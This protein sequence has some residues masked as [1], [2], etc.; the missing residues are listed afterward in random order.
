MHIESLFSE[1]MKTMRPSEI[2]E[3]L[4][5]TQNPEIISF[6]G[7]L[8]NPEAFP[9][10]E[11]VEITREILEK[12]GKMALQYGPTEGI[13]GFREVLASR[14]AKDGM[15]A[16][17]ENVIITTGSQQ[18]LDMIGRVFLDPGDTIIVELPTYLGAI[19]A[20]RAYEVNFEG[21]PLDEEGMKTDL[22]EEKIEELKKKGITPKFIYVVP[23][24][25]NPAGVVMSESRRRKLIDIANEHDLI[26]IEDDPYGKLIY[27][28]K[29][30]KPIKALDDEGR[31]I[32]LST[33]SKI[34]APGFRL[35][36]I[37][38][39]EELIR[40]L[41]IAKQALDLCSNTFVQFV[42]KEFIEG[43]YLDL[44]IMKII[45]MYRP[46]RDKMIEAIKNYFP[47]DTIFYKPRGGMFAWVTIP[48]NI[49][50]EEMFLDAI[51][52]KVAYIHGKAFYVDGGGANSMRLNFSYSSEELIDEGMRRLGKVIEKKL[53][54]TN[55]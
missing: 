37:V 29:P 54:E 13:R 51:K 38:A 3:L 42:A 14:C 49:D 36:W 33:F 21:V 50:T 27:E 31:V 52:E 48:G 15:D 6:A 10:D 23:T 45:E 20:F 8:P 18:G 11:L 46:K 34:L 19:N 2:R 32:Y 44:H 53:K 16:T 25:Q 30:A 55:S 41:T 17:S 40:K 12:H 43:G 39:S 24:F 47:S 5:L 9:V 4:K 26:V 1:R 22:L 7:G 35:A 28:G